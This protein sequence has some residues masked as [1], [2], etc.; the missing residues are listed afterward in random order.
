[1]HIEGLY[2]WAKMQQKKKLRINGED[3]KVKQDV[4]HSN[5]LVILPCKDSLQS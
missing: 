3:L 2:S 5:S 4:C 1:M